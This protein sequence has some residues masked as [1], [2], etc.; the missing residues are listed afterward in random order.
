MGSEESC[1]KQML[2][3]S[4]FYRDNEAL[5]C[6]GHPQCKPPCVFEPNKALFRAVRRASGEGTLTVEEVRCITL[7]VEGY[8]S[9]VIL[10]EPGPDPTGRVSHR[11]Q[12]ACER[13]YAK[14]GR[15]VCVLCRMLYSL[16]LPKGPRVDEKMELRYPAEAFPEIRERQAVGPIRIRQRHH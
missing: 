11:A 3:G 6:M 14:I 2:S 1:L 9:S 8:P 4:N 15:R 13:A 10:R 7:D 16:E 5:R 12:Y